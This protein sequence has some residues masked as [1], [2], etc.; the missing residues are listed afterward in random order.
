M[1]QQQKQE[2]RIVIQLQQRQLMLAKL[3]QTA[4]YDV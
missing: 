3:P 1:L 4:E 2:S